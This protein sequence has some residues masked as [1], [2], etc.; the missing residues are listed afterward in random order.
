MKERNVLFNV[1]LNTFRT[2]TYPSNIYTKGA[3]WCK[4]PTE[5]QSV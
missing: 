3:Q 5:A 4:I 2:D 1:A